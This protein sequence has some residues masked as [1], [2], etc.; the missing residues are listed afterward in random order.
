M[1]GRFKMLRRNQLRLVV[2]CLEQGLPLARDLDRLDDMP[3]AYPG[4]IVPIIE[5]H[6]GHLHVHELCWGFDVDWQRGRV[7][8]TRIETALGPRPGMWE[9]PMQRGRCVVATPAFF[10][11]HRDKTQRGKSGRQVKA[12]YLFE[13]PDATPLLLAAIAAD[14]R[15]S[16]VTTEPNASVAP[17]H[18]RM[19]LVLAQH[20][21]P[22]WFG[23]DY[24]MLADRSAIALV[25]Q[26]EDPEAL[27]PEQE[28]L[29]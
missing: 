16:I 29:F 2:E 20:E 23:P 6:D 21:L 9:L 14:D 5:P 7:F 8:N 27:A 22:L 28:S 11:P 4:S 3:T 18:D 19:P 25:A 13:S 10:E 26:P 1:C 17:I 15:F 24:A 12:Q